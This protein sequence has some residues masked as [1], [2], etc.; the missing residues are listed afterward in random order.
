ML[1]TLA[2]PHYREIGVKVNKYTILL[3][4]L[5]QKNFSISKKILK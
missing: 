4:A 5:N 2:I 3:H 1:K